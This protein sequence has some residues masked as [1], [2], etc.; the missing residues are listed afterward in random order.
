LVL[1]RV[2]NWPLLFFVIFS[3]N[4]S[5]LFRRSTTISWCVG[6]GWAGR[7]FCK[8]LAGAMARG[9]LQMCLT[10]KGWAGR[11]ERMLFVFVFRG[12]VL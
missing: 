6:V 3:L 7:L 9:G 11:L 10:A 1:Q 8:P 5:N 2:G 4:I 12:G